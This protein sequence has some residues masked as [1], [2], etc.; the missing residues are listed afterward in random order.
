MRA[1]THFRLFLASLIMMLSFLF[2]SCYFIRDNHWPNY[3]YII[4]AVIT[5]FLGFLIPD[6]PEAYTITSGLSARRYWLL[7]LLLGK[8]YAEGVRFFTPKNPKWMDE[9]DDGLQS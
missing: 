2:C 6:S 3:W 7:R 8:R 5:A 4:S 9:D 1:S